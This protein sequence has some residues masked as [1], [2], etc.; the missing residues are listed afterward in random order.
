MK[1][2]EQI[3]VAVDLGPQSEDVLATA[4]ALAKKFGSKVVLL[5]VLAPM[6]AQTPSGERYVCLARQA[7]TERL[8]QLWTHLE[9]EKV[10]AEEVVVEGVAFDQIISQAETCDANVIVLG[11]GAGAGGS[12]PGITAERICRKAQKPVWVVSPGAP[13]FP[14]SILCPVDFSKPSERAL[15]NAIHLA[16]SYAAGLTILTV[17]VPPSVVFAWFGSDDE[18]WRQEESTRCESRFADFLQRFDFHSVT[19]QNLVRFGDP[20]EQILAVAAD[21][22][23]DLIVMGSVGS[24]GLSRILLGS[25][26]SNVI[27]QLPCSI[28]TVK[29]EDAFQLRLSEQVGNFDTHL[30][31]GIQLLEQGLPREAQREFQCCVTINPMFPTAW[32][33]LAESCRR[34][35]DQ[36]RAEECL[37]IAK[38]VKDSLA[39]QQVVADIRRNHP[40]WKKM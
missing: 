18:R 10:P 8:H 40:F 36:A 3:L 32:E 7:A 30:R 21:Q 12:R 29:A 33:G 15:R 24:T 25:V 1:L 39:W 4:S 13:G 27:R 14:R 35:H 16:R 28:V 19:C 37:R 22:G 9:D 11:S 31:Q 38:E 26:T 20:S 34:L 6:D 2:L 17:I 5:H 23:T